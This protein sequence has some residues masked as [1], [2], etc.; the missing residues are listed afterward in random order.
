MDEIKKDYHTTKNKQPFNP[1]CKTVCY[2][3]CRCKPRHVYKC[4]ISERLRRYSFAYHNGC[5]RC[6]FYGEEVVC[7]FLRTQNID[8]RREVSFPWSGAY[9]RFD[10]H[11]SN[12][13]ILIEI[14]GKQHFKGS[15][16]FGSSAINRKKDVLKMKQAFGAG[17]HVI[18]INQKDLNDRSSFDWKSILQQTLSLCDCSLSASLFIISSDTFIY[19]KHVQELKK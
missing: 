14:D 13:N 10:I 19:D 11:I 1:S 18:R 9:S 8:Y 3:K 17:F 15:K 4:T 12:K 5:P 2:W 16:K 6:I 7:E